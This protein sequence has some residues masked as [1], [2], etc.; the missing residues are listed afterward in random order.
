LT[1]TPKR[2]GV[3]DMRDHTI[4]HCDTPTRIG[5]LHSPAAEARPS[6]IDGLGPGHLSPPRQP[7]GVTQRVTLDV[8]GDARQQR[9][10]PLQPASAWGIWAGFNS[11]A[12]CAPHPSSVTRQQ[13]GARRRNRRASKEAGIVCLASPSNDRGNPR[14]LSACKGAD[15]GARR[16]WVSPFQRL[17]FDSHG[18]IDRAPSGRRAG[19]PQI[20]Q[21]GPAYCAV[22]RLCLACPGGPLRLPARSVAFLGSVCCS[23]ADPGE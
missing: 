6:P 10:N 18:R 1:A 17:G 9:P 14:Y 21:P 4:T 11:R 3:D 8:D 15:V 2:A 12:C 22:V 7:R 5:A 23:L 19:A 20:H 13:P 16:C